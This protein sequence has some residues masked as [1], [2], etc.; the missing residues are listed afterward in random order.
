[1]GERGVPGTCASSYSKK[2]ETNCNDAGRD[3]SQ[4]KKRRYQGLGRNSV[5]VGEE[6]KKK[7]GTR[8]IKRRGFL[9]GTSAVHARAAG[10]RSKK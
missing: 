7:K 2:G 9:A 4:K 1:V 6:N 5:L 3:S 8:E 10:G